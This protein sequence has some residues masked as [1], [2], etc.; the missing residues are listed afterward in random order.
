MDQ[1][2]SARAERVLERF[3][4]DESLTSDLTDPVA[5]ALLDWITQQVQAADAVA[6]DALFQARVAAI[7]SAARAA[8]QAAAEDDSA[9]VVERAQAAL[10]L[11]APG[12]AAAP[13][14]PV[15]AASAPSTPSDQPASATRPSEQPARRS[16][17]NSLRRQVRR[18]VYR[19]V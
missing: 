14:S 17:W 5:T 9:P 6:D 3:S 7:R 8:A 16:L 2:L 13:D 15:T 1:K 4:E 11:P 19:K 18:W 12:A 10:S